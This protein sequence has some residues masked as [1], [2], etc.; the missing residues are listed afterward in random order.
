MKTNALLQRLTSLGVAVI[1]LASPDALIKIFVN[2]SKCFT[3]VDRGRG[4]A[5]AQS[6]RERASGGELRHRSNIGKAR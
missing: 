1:V 5:A 2:E 4:M 3:L 6:E